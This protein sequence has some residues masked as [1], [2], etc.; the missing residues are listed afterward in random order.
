MN[1]LITIL[2]TLFIVVTSIDV[3]AQNISVSSFQLDET[4]LTANLKESIVLD[5]N[6]NKCALIQLKQTLILM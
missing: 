3:T 1:R 5:Q 4:D 6:G 2:I